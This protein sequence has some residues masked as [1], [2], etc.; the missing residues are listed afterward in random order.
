MEKRKTSKWALGSMAFGVTAAILLWL[1]G[2]GYQWGWWQF[3]TALI[4]VI[5]SSSI[6]ALISFALSLVF[7]AARRNKPSIKGIVPAVVGLLLSITVIGVI[8]YWFTEAQ[9]YPFIHDITTDIENPPEFRAVVPLRTEAQND[10]AYNREKNAD[11]QRSYYPDIQPIYLD[12]T[13]S[14]AFERA[15][16]ATREMEW[17]QI[18]S[19]DKQGGTIEAVDQLAWFGFKDDIIIRL[20]TAKVSDDIKLDMRSAS[21]IG[22]S[23][24][25]RNAQRIRVFMKTIKNR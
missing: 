19:V 5:P 11:F 16:E 2:Y 18:V 7:G 3:S 17:E 12:M 4:W 15:L 8:G 10:I 14:E 6:L 24:I 9:Q 20:D 1:S 13:Y 23:D 21:R 22:K 25:G